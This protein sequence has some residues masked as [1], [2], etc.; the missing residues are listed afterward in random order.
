MLRSIG[1]DGGGQQTET[2]FS[3]L[4]SM[5]TLICLSGLP[6]VGKTSIA[7][8]LSKQINAVHVRIDSIEVAMKNSTLKIHPAEDAGY[9]V[10]VAVAKDNLT[11]GL[12]VIADTVNPIDTTRQWWAGAAQ[13]THAVLLN[14][15]IIC[16]DKQEH[17]RRVETRV[18]DIDGLILP[19][20]KK[21]GLRR[22]DPWIEPR[23]VLDSGKLS[24]P[25]CVAAIVEELSK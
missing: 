25:E 12:D 4:H 24:L 13:A 6:G 1:G 20:W 15:E 3:L 11:L 14:V 23:L 5:A 21:I 17:R 7:R 10:A 18:S 22:Y 16:R 19:S 2:I 9:L 8:E